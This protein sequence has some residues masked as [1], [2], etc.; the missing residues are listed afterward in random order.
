M[1]LT[2]EL[3]HGNICRV[4][5]KHKT[6]QTIPN[7]DTFQAQDLKIDLLYFVFG[8]FWFFFC[9]N[10]GTGLLHYVLLLRHFRNSK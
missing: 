3:T 4:I 5:D 7:E 1:K 8:L 9:M 2:D 10:H 6:R